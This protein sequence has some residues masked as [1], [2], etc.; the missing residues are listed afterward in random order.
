MVKL[1]HL[2]VVLK[3]ADAPDA[4]TDADIWLWKK[5]WKEVLPDQPG[6]DLEIGMTTSYFFSP[7]NF[8]TEDFQRGV[9]LEND[10]TGHK[11]G[12]RCE[13][14]LIL[15]L[16]L[17]GKYYPLVAMPKIIGKDGKVGEWLAGS[18]VQGRRLNLTTIPPAKMGGS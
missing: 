14:V 6:N 7:K 9:F 3:T 4:G 8:S 1:K 10:N 11:P 13:S 2:W 16:G 12:W 5:D 18:N 15:G 17:D